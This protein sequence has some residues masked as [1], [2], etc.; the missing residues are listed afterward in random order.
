[1]TLKSGSLS[2]TSCALKLARLLPLSA[3]AS[4]L[5]DRVPWLYA[6]PHCAALP[7]LS[8]EVHRLKLWLRSGVD[9]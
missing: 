3:P 1:M 9:G 7:P 4:V 6:L 5:Y 2:S 8:L